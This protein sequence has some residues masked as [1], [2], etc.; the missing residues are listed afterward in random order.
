MKRIQKLQ[1]ELRQNRLSAVLIS[2]PQNV[3]Y[4]S[5]F[6]GTNGRLLITPKKAVL[7]TDFRYLRSARKQLPKTV[8]VY[9]QKEGLKKLLGRFR[10]LGIED[11]HITHARFLDYKKMLKGVRLKPVSGL[12][13]RMRV[14]KDKHEIALIKK[15]VA[16]TEKALKKF[17]KTI[18]TG[19]SEDEMEWNL[20][21]IVRRLGG[22]RFSFS[23]IISFGKNTADV[24]HQKEPNK[25]KKGEKILIDFGIRYQRYMTDMTRVFY[26][27]KPDSIEQKIY[28]TVLAANQ[29]AIN[30]VKTG[31]KL[32]EVDQAARAVIEK[33]GYGPHFGHATGHGVGLE[34]HE[35]PRVSET[36]DDI[37]RPGMVFTIE[38]GIYL[39]TKGGVRLEDMV[40]VNEKGKAEVLTH[41]PKDLKVIHS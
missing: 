24:H 1:S 35:D 25:L 37:I 27:Q 6:A 36:S 26:T 29:A 23:P 40:Y 9:D 15:A 28:S 12:A 2:K 41:F 32:S 30:A 18:K 17:E 31:R 22:D 14:I 11:E 7:I 19:Q 13:E 5:G 20:L 34:V 38:P 8:T 16:I 4:L 3:Y 10:T 33:A 39:N 21:T